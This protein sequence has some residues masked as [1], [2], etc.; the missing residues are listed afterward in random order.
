MI[1]TTLAVFAKTVRVF[2]SQVQSRV[3]R[4]ENTQTNE[5]RIHV[6]ECEPIVHIF[7]R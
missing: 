3:V 5:W 2:N 7:I 6:V 4:V 1:M